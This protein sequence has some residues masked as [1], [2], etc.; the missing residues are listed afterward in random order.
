MKAF[1][2]EFESEYPNITVEY[3]PVGSGRAREKLLAESRAGTR[4]TPRSSTPVSS[5]ISRPAAP[6]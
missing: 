1:K 3:E 5:R 2:E 4:R 6:R